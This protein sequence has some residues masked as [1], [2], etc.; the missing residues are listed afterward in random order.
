MP[1][2]QSA[3]PKRYFTVEQA[4]LMLPLLRAIV[5][6]IRDLAANLRQRQERRG[7]IRADRGSSLGEWYE[8][9]ERRADSELERDAAKLEEYIDELRSLGVQLKGWEGVVDFPSMMDGREVCLCW[10]FGEPEVAHWHEVDAGFAGRQPLF[11][12][13]ASKTDEPEQMGNGDEAEA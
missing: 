8:E 12:A 5:G 13:A 3:R 6:D 1:E 4:N 7:R 11:A 10:K 2:P 9:E